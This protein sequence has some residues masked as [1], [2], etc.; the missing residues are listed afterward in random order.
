MC[1][2]KKRECRRVIE[3]PEFGASWNCHI[4]TRRNIVRQPMTRERGRQA[5]SCLA[6]ARTD[7]SGHR[8]WAPVYTSIGLIAAGQRKFALRLK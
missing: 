7:E 1:L 8:Y 2:L 3:V 4:N 5:K 6:L